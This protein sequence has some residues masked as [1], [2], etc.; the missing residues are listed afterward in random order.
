[1][2]NKW[3]LESSVHG[4]TSGHMIYITAVNTGLSIHLFDFFNLLTEEEFDPF[5][6]KAKV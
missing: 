6:S 5:K 3:A 4:Y 2:W 1:M